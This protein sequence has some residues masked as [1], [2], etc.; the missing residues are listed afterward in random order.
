MKIIV[1]DVEEIN[2]VIKM[3]YT[4]DFEKY[5]NNTNSLFH[6]FTLWQ[7][8]DIKPIAFLAWKAGIAKT[9]RDYGLIKP[10]GE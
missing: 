6:N 10:K 1:L 5:W 2:G 9:K 3:K 4:K 7:W 8:E